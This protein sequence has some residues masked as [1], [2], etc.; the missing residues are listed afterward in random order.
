[1]PLLTPHRYWFV[2]PA[3]GVGARMNADK[4]KQYLLLANKTILEH[5]L[6]R[7]LAFPG[8][9]G[10]VVPLSK[11]DNRWTALTILQHPLVHTIHGGESRADSV[12]HGLNY[13]ADKVHESD[14]ILVHDAA[15]PCITL[16]RIQKLCDELAESE[17]GGIL[18]VPVS[19]TLKQ[20]ADNIYIQSTVDRKPLWQ[21]QTP[22]M[23]RYGLLR[24]CLKKTIDKKQN[25]TDESSAVELCGYR[26]Q[27]VEG[28][29][30]NIKITRPD[31]L[32]MAEFILNQQEK[33]S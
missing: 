22:Q 15:R 8:L 10:I 13:L 7:I 19:D 30:D 17:T 2:V 14:W 26:S 1:M 4:P 12:L 29:S 28:R 3:A 20:V 32:L 21:A 6:S 11:D 18:A 9:A 31:D 16:E 25:I 5:T 23:F 24:D 27:V 33:R